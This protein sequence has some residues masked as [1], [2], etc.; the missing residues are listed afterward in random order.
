[1]SALSFPWNLSS[2]DPHS[3]SPSLMPAA[4]E[5]SRKEAVKPAGMLVAVPLIPPPM[6]PSTDAMCNALKSDTGE[7]TAIL[8]RSSLYITMGVPPC[9]DSLKSVMCS[10]RAIFRKRSWYENT[11]WSIFTASSSV[12]AITAKAGNMEETLLLVGGTAISSWNVVS[13]R[14]EELSESNTWKGVR[15][16]RKAWRREK[17]WCDL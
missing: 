2:L 14:I 5:E 9:H 10:V 11:L 15:V 12:S 4:L 13:N 3:K 17:K 8:D 6:A 1:M 7:S 16:R